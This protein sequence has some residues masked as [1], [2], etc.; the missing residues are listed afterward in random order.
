MEPKKIL[1]KA[2]EAMD[3]DLCD[4]CLGRL[5][6]QLGHGL[7]NDERGCTLR[8]AYAMLDG[9]RKRTPVPEETKD[10]SL[11]DNLFEE[12]ITLSEYILEEVENF[13]FDTF[14][15]GSR[16]D[17]EIEEREER[18]WAKLDI[19]NSEPIKSEVNREIGKL[20]DAELEAEVDLKKPDIKCIVDTRFHSIDIELSPL[21][22]YG[23]YCKLSRQI[24]QTKWEC[25]K[26]RGVGC[27]HCDGKGK[28]YETSV[29]E[30]IGEPLLE[31]TGGSDFTLHGMGREDIDALMLGSGRPF[32]IEVKEPI[33][34]NV[35]FSGLVETIEDD[36]RVEISDLKSVGRDEVKKIKS[37]KSD[38]SYVVKVR[39]SESVDRGK[40]K[41]VFLSLR[42]AEI[43][44]RTPKRVSHRRADKIRKRII[45]QLWIEECH[46]DNASIG[47]KCES[48]TYVKEFIHGDEGRTVPN[49]SDSIGVKCEVQGLNV[50][51]VHY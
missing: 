24:P 43:S 10:C 51:E 3:E 12:L 7:T 26:C 34:R 29:E 39:F 17:P 25:K 32:V 19:V 16:V 11:C 4:H 38:K 41:K 35:D 44:Q 21:F 47:L 48:G 8:I 18:L 42:G 45:K 27:D 46:D 49:L 36:D 2:K 50:I 37:A 22:I 15:V 28:M 1:S 13:E 33:R 6:A 20:V 23:R 9:E 5:F 40:L 31:L 30:I 14:L